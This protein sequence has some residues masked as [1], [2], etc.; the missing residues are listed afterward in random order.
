[1]KSHKCWSF[2]AMLTMIGTF[3]TG[4]KNQKTAHEYFAMSSL[5]CMMMAIYT[6]HK[7]ISRSKK[8]KNTIESAENEE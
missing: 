5:L 4:Y 6:G 7:M 3:Y 1:M 2:G 8:E